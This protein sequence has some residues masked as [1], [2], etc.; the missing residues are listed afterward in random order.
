MSAKDKQNFDISSEQQSNISFPYYLK[1][2]KQEISLLS[3][4]FIGFL[5]WICPVPQGLSTQ[6]WHLLA[7]FISTILGIIFK[8]LPM[9][10]ISFLSLVFLILSNTLTFDQAFFRF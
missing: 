7:I 10:A 4:F 8:P 9:G 3:I 6:A 1:R 2:F 5:I